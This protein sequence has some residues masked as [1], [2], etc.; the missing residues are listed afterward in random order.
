MLVASL[1]TGGPMR[2]FAQSALPLKGTLSEDV[3]SA[4]APAVEPEA[5]QRVTAKLAETTL[6]IE[7]LDP[8]PPPPRARVPAGDPYAP[9]G[10]GNAGLT[11]FPSI[12]IGSVYSS[13]VNGS[14]ASP[15]SDIGLVIKPSL[16]FESDWVRHSLTGGVEG[17]LVSFAN[18]PRYD[19]GTADIF[20]RL[21]LDVRRNIQ[22]EIDASYAYDD[23]GGDDPVE[24]TLAGSVGI[25]QDFGPLAALI[26][27]GVTDKTFEDIKSGGITQDNSD[28]DYIEPSFTIRTS[29]TGSGILKPYIE[30][31][32]APRYHNRIP[33][34]FGLNRD[35]EGYAVRAGV[36]FTESPIWSGDLGLTFLHRNYDDSAFDTVDALGFAGNLAWNPTELTKVV[37]AAD[38]SIDE[39]DIATSAA[40]RTWTTSID[41]THALHDNVDLTAG[42]SLEVEDFGSSVDKTYDANIGIAWK[43]NP[44]LTWTAGYDLTWLDSATAGDSYVEHRL[45][46]GMTLSR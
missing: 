28:R 23:P 29:Y 5:P 11:V 22:A 18:N 10:I 1:L 16:R 9:A 12:A 20:E 4:D 21:R 27:A 31:S 45:S 32:L 43:F 38:T 7:P 30:A 13:N 36:E 14:D 25:T 3:A 46:T 15:R 34:R 26:K 24:H 33:D 40:K 17:S 41:I 35:S 37:M 8:P 42:A 19:T 2:A 39:T 6:E 44:V